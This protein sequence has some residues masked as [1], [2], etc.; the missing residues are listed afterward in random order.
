MPGNLSLTVVSKY[1]KSITM[2][3]T[4]QFRINPT[5]K[6]ETLLLNTLEFCRRLYNHLLEQRK[7]SWEEEKKGLSLYDQINTFPILKERVPELRDVHS[8][9][10]QNVAVRVDL[11]FKAFFRRIKQG[12]NPGY[13]RFRGY[14]RYDSFT[15]P[16]KGWKIAEKTVSLSKIGKVKA[17]YHRP[18]EG[19][20]KTCT[21]KKTATGKWFVSFSCEV[22]KKPLPE[23]SDSIGIDAGL[24]SF[25]T[26]SD[27]TKIENPHF[28]KTEEKSLA[29]A[30]RSLFK[31]A[32]GSK[33]RRKARKVVA[34][35]HERISNRR[36]NFT[37]QLSRG[38]VN[39]YGIIAIEDLSIND[40]Q[41]DNFRCM[42]KGIADV[43]WRGFFDL[44]GHKA[45]CADRRV[46][47]VNP[48]YTS[49]TCSRCGYRQKM[50]LSN[51]TFQCPCCNLSLDRDH[52][53]A[54]NIHSLGLQTVGL[55]SVEAP[56]F[57]RGE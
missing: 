5:K 39:K 12:V 19:C 41:K 1:S 46:I 16:Q 22:A 29:K 10:L 4:F 30:Q 11:G 56:G 52:N 34:R 50:S 53:A 32:K 17:I 15:F 20:V 38:L 37:H 14:G 45:E 18:I 25:A 24:M 54:I 55:K 44:L 49:Q 7:T 6:Q 48:A 3:K 13:P 9:V 43:A 27:G 36:H 26:L 47:R 40:M 33:K 35:V 21:V 57:S 2:R 23:C 31:Q 42:N 28:F 51:R 8:Q